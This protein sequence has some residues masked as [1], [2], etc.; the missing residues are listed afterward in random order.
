VV[1]ARWQRATAVAVAIQAVVGEGLTL[2]EAPHQVLAGAWDAAGGHH[3][4]SSTERAVR[5][6]G[7]VVGWRSSAS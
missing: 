7:R 5:P 6:G 2:L 3:L 1:R 4:P